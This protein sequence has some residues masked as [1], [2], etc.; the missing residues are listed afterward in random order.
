M[1][2]DAGRLAVSRREVEVAP[3]GARA[4]KTPDDDP[5]RA[6]LTEAQ[7]K[8]LLNIET[9]SAVRPRWHVVKGL[10]PEAIERVR[11][12]LD[13]VHE[14]HRQSFEELLTAADEEKQQERERGGER[15]P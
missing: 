3:E 10:E 2:G 8:R 15:V 13:G 14:R 7:A 4:S 5:D 6:T 9:G 12:H 11:Q 1:T